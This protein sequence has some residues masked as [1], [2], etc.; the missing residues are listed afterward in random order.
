MV[1]KIERV[2]AFDAQEFTVD[3]GLVAVIGANN[4]VVADAESGLAAIRAVRADGADMLH[5]PGA[6]LITVRSAG[7][8]AD[9]ADVDAHAALVAFQMVFV[10]G[11]DLRER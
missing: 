7:Q 9:R 8:R 1:R 3:T 5:F 2:T 4:L 6:C 11:R 10:I